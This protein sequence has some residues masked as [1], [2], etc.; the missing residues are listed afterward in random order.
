MMRQAREVILM[1]LMT[2]HVMSE[3]RSNSHIDKW[4]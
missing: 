2:G 4:R 1:T 3:T